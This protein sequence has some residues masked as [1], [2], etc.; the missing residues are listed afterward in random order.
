MITELVGKT[1][2]KIERHEDELVFHCADGTKYKMFHQRDCCE[3]VV[4]EDITGDLDDLIGTP[5]IKATEDSNTD[6]VIPTNVI[7]KLPKEH[8]A[9][10]VSQKLIG[11][12]DMDDSHT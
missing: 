11:E 12:K 3:S 2:S 1:L 4:I 8:V 5:I 7:D 10:L 6:D 9:K